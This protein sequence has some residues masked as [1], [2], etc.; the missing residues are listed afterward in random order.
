MK[1]PRHGS[2]ATLSCLMTLLALALALVVV[3][4]N[5]PSN[6]NND[7]DDATRS[8]RISVVSPLQTGAL[9]YG[10]WSL[11]RKRAQ[12]NSPMVFYVEL[13]SSP[14]PSAP[15]LLA[16]ATPNPKFENMPRIY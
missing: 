2:M 12:S 7:D 13:R 15:S 14:R 11:S 3:S 6:N 4:A 5:N 8:S 9:T 10:G 1:K 16:Q